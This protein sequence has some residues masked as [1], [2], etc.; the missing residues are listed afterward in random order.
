[1]M[2]CF[3]ESLVMERGRLAIPEL[4]GM[5]ID[6]LRVRYGFDSCPLANGIIMEAKYH[7][8]L[9]KNWFQPLPIPS[10][11]AFVTSASRRHELSIQTLAKLGD[12]NLT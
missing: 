12:H 3:G 4:I 7:I 8:T 11:A 10:L 2:G 1:M 5:Y 6:S 9:V